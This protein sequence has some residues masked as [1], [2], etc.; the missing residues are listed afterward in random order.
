[1]ICWIPYL[2]YFWLYLCARYLGIWSVG[3]LDAHSFTCGHYMSLLQVTCL[4]ADEPNVR[5]FAMNKW[6]KAK[7]IIE[8]RLFMHRFTL[9]S[10]CYYYLFIY[11]YFYICLVLIC[12]A[13]DS[14][15]LVS[16]RLHRSGQSRSCLRVL[17]RGQLLSWIDCCM[18][19]MGVDLHIGETC[20]PCGMK[21]WSTVAVRTPRK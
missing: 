3:L 2:T 16:G 6:V 14:L 18:A 8:G 15:S 17:K 10:Y 11:L 19:A 7:T 20:P 12:E 21:D 9:W 1:M 4:A 5:E 13:W